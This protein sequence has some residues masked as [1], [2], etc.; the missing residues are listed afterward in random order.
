MIKSIIFK[1]LVLFAA[2]AT[3]NFAPYTPSFDN[4]ALVDLRAGTPVSLQLNDNISSEYVEIGN[5]VEFIVRNDVTVNGKVVIAAGSIAE[6]WV[7]DV[8]KMCEI[9]CEGRE[10]CAK[11]TIT[12]ES[13]QAVDGQRVFVRSIPH[14]V[15]GKC[16]CG[17]GPAVARIG[18][19]IS[20]RVQND[21]KI[22]A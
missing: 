17:G 7:K 13:V 6:G 19:V 4:P 15:R 2:F 22:D 16:C 10:Y 8:E 11:L 20:A 18:T 3:M 1:S 9:N 21:A 12:V 5:A 14:T